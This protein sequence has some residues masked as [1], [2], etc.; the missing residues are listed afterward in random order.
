[1]ESEI[2][3]LYF[4]VLLIAQIGSPHME[5]SILGESGEEDQLGKICGRAGKRVREKD[6]LHLTRRDLEGRFS[7]ERRD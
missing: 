1:M 4:T 7:H 2:T 6:L 3:R 5:E